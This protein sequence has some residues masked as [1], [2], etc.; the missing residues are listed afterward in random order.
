MPF[1][2]LDMDDD[3]NP[4][5]LFSF[6]V[7]YRE[8]NQP[9]LAAISG[10]PGKLFYPVQTL[11]FESI[12][13]QNGDTTK[14]TANQGNMQRWNFSGDKVKTADTSNCSPI[15]ILFRNSHPEESAQ[16]RCF[17]K[18]GSPAGSGNE[19]YIVIRKKLNGTLKMGWLKC[20]YS[21]DTTITFI[22]YKKLAEVTELTLP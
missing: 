10:S 9:G 6:H 21:G 4:D 11:P 15:S 22:S 2:F 12:C 18:F 7:D 13:I 19:G 17:T 5:F 20:R 1:F 16:T 8:N 3:K 14:S